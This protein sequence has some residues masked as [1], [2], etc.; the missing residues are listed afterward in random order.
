MEAPNSDQYVNQL[1]V[2]VY[3]YIFKI[4]WIPTHRRS[5]YEERD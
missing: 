1:H 2:C 4:Y 3:V 5:S